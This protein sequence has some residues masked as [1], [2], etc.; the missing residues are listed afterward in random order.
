MDISI[1]VPSAK[2]DNLQLWNDHQ[3]ETKP[4]MSLEE[5]ILMKVSKETYDLYIND[6]VTIA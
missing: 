5:F 3:L 6:V 2:R 1:K 4:I